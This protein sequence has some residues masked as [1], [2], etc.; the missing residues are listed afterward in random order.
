MSIAV[1]GFTLHRA[2]GR[3]CDLYILFRE[4]QEGAGQRLGLF[5]TAARAWQRARVLRDK[6]FLS[7]MTP[8]SHG[9]GPRLVRP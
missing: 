1:P 5:G 7:F 6:E 3:D 4:G 8:G 9:T 2:K